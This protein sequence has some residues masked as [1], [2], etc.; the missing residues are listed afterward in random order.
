MSGIFGSKIWEAG[1][2]SQNLNV[3]LQA[4]EGSKVMVDPQKLTRFFQQL[5]TIQAKIARLQAERT[6]NALRE[7][8]LRVRAALSKSIA[9][10]LC[11]AL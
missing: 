2:W 11:R 8:N 4:G 7:D 1:A 5:N 6:A 9:A 10:S 3:I